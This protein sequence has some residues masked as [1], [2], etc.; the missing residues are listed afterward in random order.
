VNVEIPINMVVANPCVEC[1]RP[2]P[3]VEYRVP[4]KINCVKCGAGYVLTTPRGEKIWFR[5][6]GEDNMYPKRPLELR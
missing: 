5:R 4:V 2:L 1:G 6:Y 3:S